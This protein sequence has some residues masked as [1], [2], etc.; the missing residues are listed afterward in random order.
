MAAILIT[1]TDREIA[2][3]SLLLK[4]FP[5]K[6]S[7]V[8]DAPVPTPA[9]P[10]IDNGGQTTTDSAVSVT[11]EAEGQDSNSTDENS[12]EGTTENAEAGAEHKSDLEPKG[13][14]GKSNKA[15]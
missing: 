12:G 6:I 2:K 10:Q 14:R 1:G 7:R 4:N 5:V 9:P 11:I 13:K 3:V 8:E 15:K